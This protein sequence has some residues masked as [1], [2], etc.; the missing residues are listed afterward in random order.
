MFLVDHQLAES[1]R[2]AH[3]YPQNIIT[4]TLDACAWT[5]TGA[6]TSLD[7]ATPSLFV[8]REEEVDLTFR[9]IDPQEG[10]KKT[11]IHLEGKELEWL[12]VQSRM[13]EE[14]PR[15]PPF[16]Y[17]QRRDPKCRFIYI[18]GIHSRAALKVSRSMLTNVLSYHEV[19]PAYLDFILAFGL[20]YEP[21]DLKF[22]AFM[23]QTTLSAPRGPVT[24]E[25]GR[26]GRQFQLCYN[27]RTAIK[28]SEENG[29]G[30]HQEWSIQPAAIHHQFDVIEGTTLWIV[31]KGGRDLYH[32][33]KDFSASSVRPGGLAFTSPEECLR[34]SLST[35]LMFCRWA[36]EGWR[37]FLKWLEM[38]VEEETQLAGYSPWKNYRS[39]HLVRLHRHLDKAAGIVIA[40]ETNVDILTLLREYY[41]KL[42][43]SYDYPSA[44]RNACS[45]DL[46]CFDTKLGVMVHNSKMELFRAKSLVDIVKDRKELIVQHLQTQASERIEAVS[47]RMEREAIAVRM[48]TIVFGV[49]LPGS[50]VS[51]F[52]STDVVHYSAND[53]EKVVFSSIALDRWLQL[54][55][56]LTA[57][58]LIFV[59]W[60]H[61]FAN[62]S[63]MFNKFM[64]ANAR[65]IARS[66][67]SFALR[68]RATIESTTV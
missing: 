15:K 10:L 5:L 58:T 64:L 3:K 20:K 17:A 4:R 67:R 45:D 6:T 57:L 35:H 56:P 2:G 32:R 7:K 42:V 30:N 27:L 41:C 18:Y 49:Y 28:K 33:Y 36:T 44:L 51:A 59:Y 66:V 47:N 11:N 22:S 14:C 50:F 46:H 13:N 16:I 25:L 21:D 26:S 23:E 63:A 43:S 29:L 38:T 9:D 31:T 54:T 52:F 62:K 39:E 60:S 24:T 55:V 61:S 40:L 19:M 34:S 65:G 68:K 8:K 48:L 12:G 37:W 53:N 1:I